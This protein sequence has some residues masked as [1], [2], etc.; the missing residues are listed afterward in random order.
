[1][2]MNLFAQTITSPTYPGGHVQGIAVDTARGYIYYSFTTLLVKA[3]MDGQTVGS[4]RGL[5]GHLGCLAFNPA[6]GLVYGSLEYKRDAIGAGIRQSL[7]LGGASGDGF[8]VAM[9]D[10]EKIKREN[11]DAEGDGIMRCVHLPTVLEDYEATVR[12]AA[13]PRKHRYGC[14]GIDGLSIGPLFGS[15]AQGPWGLCVA[16]GI[17]S[18]LER[19]DNDHQVLLRYDTGDWDRLSRPLNQSRMHRSGAQPQGKYFVFTGNTTYGVQNLEYDAFT[20]HWFMA[21]YR[22]KKPQYPNRDLYIIDGSAQPQTQL[23]AGLGGETGQ[24]LCLWQRGIRHEA[25]G[26][27]AWDSPWGTTGIFSF[28]NGY[29]YLSQ[30]GRSE[31]GF[32]TQ[33]QR[34]RWTGEAPFPFVEG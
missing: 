23:L 25:T 17:Y 19:Q 14:S 32:Y 9:F 31:E 3:R 27:H 7:G 13:G 16:Y 18:D 22:G 12:T 20:G 28:G 11:M 5:T 8:Y 6:D 21:V 30:D 26:I 34:Y 29:F 24:T 1:M 4:V 2:N 15:G 33:V 10:G